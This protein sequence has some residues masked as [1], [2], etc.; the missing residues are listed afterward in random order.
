MLRDINDAAI[1]WYEGI[2]EEMSDD[3]SQW[4]AIAKSTGESV[5]NIIKQVT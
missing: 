5:A 3:I 2:P 4:H 1:V